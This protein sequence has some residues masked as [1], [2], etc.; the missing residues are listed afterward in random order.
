MNTRPTLWHRLTFHAGPLL[1]LTALTAAMTAPILGRL[2][3]HVPG[4]EGDNLFYV[5]SVWWMARSWLELNI[6]PFWDPSAYYPVGRELARGEMTASNTILAL[7]ITAV[8][9]PVVAYNALLVFSFLFTSWGTYFWVHHLSG[10]R[11]AGV[12]AGAVAAFAPFRWAHMAGHLPQMTTHWVPWT[13]WAF[14]RFLARR[15]ISRGVLIGVGVA[16]TVVGCWYYGY[17]TALMFPLYAWWRSRSHAGLWRERGWWLGIAAAGVVA[18]AIALPFLLQI[19]E[20]RSAGTIARSLREMD[21]WSL[22]PWDFFIPNLFHPIWGDLAAN[23]FPVQKALWVERGV[24]LSYA[25]LFAAAA[26][27]WLLRRQASTGAL[28]TLWITS[29][30]I[31]LGPTLHWQD[32]QVRVTVPEF[33]RYSVDAVLAQFGDKGTDLRAEVSRSRD[34]PVPLPS[35]FLYLFVP[36]TSGMRAMARF[37]LWTTFATAAL[38]GLGA[39]ALGQ[40]YA[41][42]WGTGARGAIPAVIAALVLFES[43]TTFGMM[44]VNARPVDLWLRTQASATVIADLPAEESARPY[45]DYW[46]T[47]HGKATVISWNGDSYFPETRAEREV[48][49]RR[50]PDDGAI[51]YLQR[52]GVSHLLVTV[53]RYPDWAERRARLVAHPAVTYIDTFS[54][55]EVFQLASVSR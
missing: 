43:L 25:A 40:R 13:L 7:P 52:L 46:A 37:A 5:K 11:S 55:V 12:I 10:S 34:L 1:L 22:N 17:S 29:V 9:G 41:T 33:V 19:L 42:R 54:G 49:L 8:W 51:A 26:G 23:A 18:A 35:F 3:T 44:P 39:V 27:A 20:L 21:A 48:V 36:F 50:V 4:W 2:D 24:A 47:V 53:S 31:A 15:T 28:V 38:A 14:E 30:L 16:L 45:Q 32:T 6:S